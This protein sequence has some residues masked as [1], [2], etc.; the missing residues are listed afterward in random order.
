VQLTDLRKELKFNGE[1]LGLVETLKNVAGAQYHVMEK[2]KERFAQFMDSFRDF[3]KVVN[4][5]H[6]GNPLVEVMSDVLGLIIVTSDSGFMGGLNQGVIAAAMQAQGSIGDDKVSLVIIGDKGASTFHD[7]KRQFQFFKG[8]NQDTIYE[9]AGEVK[10][11]IVKAVSEKR[12]GKVIVAYPRSL[13]FS[14]QAIEVV[15]LLP[16]RELFDAASQIVP[17]RDRAGISGWLAS[18][19]DAIVESSVSDMA[20][21][22]AGVWVTSKLFEVFEDSKLAEFSARAMHLEGSVQ[23]VEKDYKKVKH[24]CFKAVRERIDKGMRESFSAKVIKE[25]KKKRH[26][27]NKD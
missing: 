11:Y 8:I 14:A 17:G 21:Y 18:A 5:I 23:K 22:L 27:D 20:E 4:L 9:Q 1:L 2:K 7:R 3:F 25:K 19:K 26:E 12:M 15:N 13:S 24:L 6:T 16:C 10:D